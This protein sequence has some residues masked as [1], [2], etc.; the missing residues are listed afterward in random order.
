M[1]R[2]L[3]LSGPTATGKTDLALKLAK[4]YSGEL[5]AAD[6]R[7]V[8][9]GLDIGTGKF[10]GRGWKME[11]RGLKKANGFW[12]INGIKVWMYDVVDLKVQYTVADY[13]RDASKVI[14]DILGRGKLPIVVGGTGL[15]IKALLER[16]DNLN[17]PVD[18]ELRGEL[19]KLNREELQEKLKLLDPVKWESLNS[20]DIQNP[21]RLVRSI[22]LASMN[23][24]MNKYQVLDNKY[25]AILRIGLTAPR[26]VLYKNSDLR[27]LDWLNKGI[28]EEVG[29]I[30]ILRRL[31]LQYGVIADLL[32]GKIK[33]ENLAILMQNKLHGFIRRQ[34]TWFK[35]EKDIVWFDITKTNLKEVEKVVGK[36][37]HIEDA[38]EN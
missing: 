32:E 35:K 33:K 1:N 31:G 36:W 5:V 21:R 34:L 25:R 28:I 37:Y 4:K 13:V 16:M 26:Q 10:P 2:L 30:Q 6:S 23:P 9:V 8:Y 12:E 15:Y 7:Q 17:I 18:P 19:E 20:S 38:K 27:V 24:Y 29:N 22:E 3:S 11:N 14:E